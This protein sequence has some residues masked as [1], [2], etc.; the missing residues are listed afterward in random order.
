MAQALSDGARAGCRPP[1]FCPRARVSVRA[2]EK[3]KLVP[4]FRMEDRRKGAY[5]VGAQKTL[6]NLVCKS[7]PRI[8]W[9]AQAAFKRVATAA[10]AVSRPFH[11]YISAWLRRC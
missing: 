10:Q 11:R 7:R 5:R 1:K 3:T 4:I 2:T 9:T 8:G 6:P